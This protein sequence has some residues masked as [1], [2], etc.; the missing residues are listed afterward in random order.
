MSDE[1]VLRNG[2]NICVFG[3]QVRDGAMLILSRVL[4]TQQSYDQNHDNHEESKSV[5]K[6]II[7]LIG[8]ENPTLLTM[9]L[10]IYPHTHCLMNRAVC[11]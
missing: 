9:H 1:Y 6:N 11:R 10:V 7:S 8:L 4:H 3:L 2:L 5:F